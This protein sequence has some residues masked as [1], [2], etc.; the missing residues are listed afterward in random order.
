[1]QISISMKIKIYLVM[2]LLVL[3]GCSENKANKTEK[4]YIE[5]PPISFSGTWIVY[6]KD[7]NRKWIEAEYI[8]GIKN[9]IELRWYPTSGDKM[10]KHTFHMG[11]LDGPY[12]KWYNYS[13]AKI[14][15]QGEYKNGQPWDGSFLEDYEENLATSVDVVERDDTLYSIREYVNGVVVGRR[16]VP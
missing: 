15:V 16:R 7:T 10:S 13:S 8:S 14:L 6:K 12:V 3:L 11:V 9:G 5:K 1:M 4:N 2:F